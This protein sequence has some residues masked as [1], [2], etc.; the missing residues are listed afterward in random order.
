MLKK[1]DVN[2]SISV[3]GARE[4]N[5]QN[6]DIQ[7]PR[8]KLVVFTGRVEVENLVWHSIQYMQRLIEDIL[9]HLVLMQ[10]ISLEM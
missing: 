1:F 6:I 7:I 10:D 8:N 4:N 9:K 5:L 2:K 3:F